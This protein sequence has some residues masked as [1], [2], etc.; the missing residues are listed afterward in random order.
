MVYVITASYFYNG[1]ISLFMQLFLMRI[2]CWPMFVIVSMISSP[3]VAS[4]QNLPPILMA[5]KPKT[6]I[7]QSFEDFINDSP[8]IQVKFVLQPRS[9][10]KQFWWGGSDYDL[11][12]PDGL[13]SM[14]KANKFWGVSD[15]DSV[16]INVSNY[17]QARGYIKFSKLGRF[18][19]T[20][21]ITSAS[22]EGNPA[23]A[24]A[25]IGGAVGGAVVY[26]ISSR[27]HEAAFIFNINNGKFI[28]LSP[29]ILNK[30]LERDEQL[31]M[32]YAQVAKRERDNPDLMLSYIEKF[33][34]R[35]MD[36]IRP[37]RL[38]KIVLYRREKKERADSITVITGDSLR[39]TLATND[40]AEFEVPKPS[41]RLCIGKECQTFPVTDAAKNYFQCL[42]REDEEGKLVPRDVKEGE[43]YTR[44][45]KYIIDHP[46]R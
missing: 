33:N 23:V 31:R 1:H 19:Y 20:K 17:Q 41:L 9:K 8:S 28:M 11:L 36:E 43:F 4:A 12:I 21:G 44:Q 10:S 13:G 46:Y 3:F 26:T 45:I 6:G 38:A 39:Y 35:H 29:E 2:V 15:G 22:L 37:E 18:C 34:Q 30:I 24:A 7:Y 25:V 42:Y 5:A 32:D 16:Y 27:Q 14:K 40:L